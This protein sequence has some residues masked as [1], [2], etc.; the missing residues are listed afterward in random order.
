MT[1]LQLFYSDTPKEQNYIQLKRNKALFVN[2][3]DV[4]VLGKLERH[5]IKNF[6]K[7]GFI[8][9]PFLVQYPRPGNS[10]HYAGTIPMGKN[11]ANYFVDKYCCLNRTKNVYLIDGSV[12]PILPAKNLTFTLMANAMRIAQFIRDKI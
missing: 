11:N 10:I 1:I 5:I 7:T 8:T 2:Y 4:P 3:T 9:I 12:F 6:W